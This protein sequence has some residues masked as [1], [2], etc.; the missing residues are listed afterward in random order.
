MK[1]D[2]VRRVSNG[3]GAFLRGIQVTE[4]P[5]R[6]G[7][8]GVFSELLNIT[9]SRDGCVSSPAPCHG[10]GLGVAVRPRAV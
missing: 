2:E 7:F 3:M 4:P 8:H 9:P 5:E 10:R 1:K 6:T